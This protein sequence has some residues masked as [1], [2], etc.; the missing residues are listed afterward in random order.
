[1]TRRFWIASFTTVVLTAIPIYAQAEEQSLS[2]FAAQFT[3][4]VEASKPVGD[5]STIQ[6]GQVATYYVEVNNPNAPT[7]ITLVWK[8]DGAEA[9]KQ[10]LDIGRS[11]RWRTWGSW[12]TRKAGTIE[13]HVLDKDGHELRSDSL[14]FAEK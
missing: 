14:S 7:Q 2:A 4:K 5:A 9:G 11:P 8:L 10:T 6:S 3:N 13:V 12:P 1:M